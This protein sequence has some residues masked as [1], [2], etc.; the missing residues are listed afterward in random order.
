[1]RP[2]LSRKPRVESLEGRLLMAY[3]AVTAT[4]VDGT[5]AIVGTN[6][7]DSI[8]VTA[9]GDGTVRLDVRG[10]PSQSW[11]AS[12][13]AALA[14]DG[15]NGDD[16]LIN[17]TRIPA[18]IAAG[19]GDHSIVAGDPA[20]PGVGGDDVITVGNGDNVIQDSGGTDAITVGNGDNVIIAHGNDAITAGNGANTIANITGAGTI[21]AGGGRDRILAGSDVTV[22]TGAHAY[23]TVRFAARPDPVTLDADGTLSFAAAAGQ[24]AVTIDDNGD[25]TITTTFTN[26]VTGLDE[27]DV[28]PAASVTAIGAIFGRGTG[29][30]LNNTNIDDVVLGGGGGTNRLTGG[31]GF[32]FLASNSPDDI[33]DGSRGASNVLAGDGPNGFLIGGTG[34]NILIAG[35]SGTTVVYSQ[36]TDDALIGDI[37]VVTLAGKRW[38]FFN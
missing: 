9:P 10:Q 15:R 8:R 20:H 23:P 27:R 16:S 25:G 28:F 11:P 18:T 14:I 7:A 33:L 5:L 38:K 17:L 4:L 35:F 6:Q 26:D 19:D 13:V 34:R 32:N 2:R 1:M 30:F 37:A 21:A 31:G 36:G 24:S 29:T 3:R 12:S 22:A